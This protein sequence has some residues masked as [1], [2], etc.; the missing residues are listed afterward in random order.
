MKI[1]GMQLAQETGW[2]D[3]SVGSDCCKPEDL[4]S[5]LQ[6]LGGKKIGV[7]ARRSATQVLGRQRQ[8]NPMSSL[9][10]VYPISA[11]KAH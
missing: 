8:R 10:M 5:D 11:C 6:H 1:K 2:R 4:N 9:Q 7:V 3:S